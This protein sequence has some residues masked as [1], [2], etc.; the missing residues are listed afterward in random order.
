M[1]VHCI[2]VCV[3]AC[4][5]V[6]GD[7]FRVFVGVDNG[8]TGD[9][10]VTLS[11]ASRNVT[12][13]TTL[14]FPVFASLWAWCALT[15]D[16]NARPDDVGGVVAMNGVLY[17]GRA[18]ANGTFAEESSVK[19]PESTPPLMPTALMSQPVT[20]DY[21]A[22]LYPQVRGEVP[23]EC[24]MALGSLLLLPPSSLPAASSSSSSSP[25]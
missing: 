12:T 7:T 13:V 4:I 14:Q 20:S 5:F 2:C 3:C 22:A 11:T 25:S 6:A 24:F 9:K 23:L 18:N 16:D 10:L 15:D 1:H 17:Y 19:I 8:G 21:F